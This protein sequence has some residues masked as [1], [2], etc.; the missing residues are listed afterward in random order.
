[1]PRRRQ[2]AHLYELAKRGAD[3]VFRELV[4][5]AKNLVDLFP[6]L[7]DSFDKDE[8]PLRFIIRRDASAKTTASAAQRPR[9]RHRRT[10]ARHRQRPSRHHHRQLSLHRRGQKAEHK[11]GGPLARSGEARGGDECGEGHAGGIER[12]SLKRFRAKWERFV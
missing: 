2:D 10:L 8:L 12:G 6:H 3:E 7:R 9:G 5:D 1:M 4:Q 11:S